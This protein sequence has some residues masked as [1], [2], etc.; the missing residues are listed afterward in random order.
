MTQIPTWL[1]VAAGAA[2]ALCAALLVWRRGELLDMARRS[3]LVLSAALLLAALTVW[4]ATLAGRRPPPPAAP[5]PLPKEPDPDPRAS[6][7]GA[8]PTPHPVDH[9]QELDPDTIPDP[10]APLDVEPDPDLGDLV[11]RLDARARRRAGTAE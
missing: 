10:A 7:D 11:L 8:P 3:P 5:S 1:A 2:L 9:A 4:L 6:G